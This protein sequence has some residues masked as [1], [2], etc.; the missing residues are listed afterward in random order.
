MTEKK[1]ENPTPFRLSVSAK[2]EL[3]QII[4]PYLHK[5]NPRASVSRNMAINEAI[6]EFAKIIKGKNK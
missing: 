1:R 5:E 3:E 6:H 2:Y 4:L